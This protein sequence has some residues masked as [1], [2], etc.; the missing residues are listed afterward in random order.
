MP[1]RPRLGAPRRLCGGD[2]VWEMTIEFYCWKI[3]RS[4]I[5]CG[6]V[7]LPYHHHLPLLRVL[8]LRAFWP[9]ARVPGGRARTGP[10]AG[11]PDDGN[12]RLGAALPLFITAFLQE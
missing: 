11:P 10:Q 5:A 6:M 2:R 1:P 9:R 3:E 12:G 8:L 4:L 7:H